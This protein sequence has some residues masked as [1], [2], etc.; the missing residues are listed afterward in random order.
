MRLK[1]VRADITDTSDP[2]YR[3]PVDVNGIPCRL[4]DLPQAT[5]PNTQGDPD[6]ITPYQNLT[7]CPITPQGE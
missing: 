5:K 3:E 7:L 6:Y 2:H 1:S 4:S